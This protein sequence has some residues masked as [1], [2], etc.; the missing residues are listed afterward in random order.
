MTARAES[1]ADRAETRAADRASLCSRGSM[2][3]P[4]K[5]PPSPSSLVPAILRSALPLGIDVESLAWRFDLPPDVL[6]REEVTVAADTAH[7][8]LQAI[9]RSSAD[10]D[11]ALRLS[12]RLTWR[13]IALADLVVRASATVRD[14]LGRLARWAPLVHDGL[15]GALEED[16]AVGRFRVRTPRRPRGL[17]RFVHELALAHAF[18]E[19]R[20]GT[21]DDLVATRVW[22]AHP[23]PPRLTALAAF[24]GTGDLA[25][26]CEDSGFALPGVALPRGL[27]AADPRTVETV[28]PLV[29]QSIAELPPASSLAQRVARRIGT[30]LPGGVDVREVARA[31]HMSARTL[32]R[33]LEDEG[34]RFTE[35]LDRARL[36]AARLLLDD[37]NRS[38]I[39]VALRV[40][41]SDL[42]SFSRAFKRWTG[43]PPGQWRR[44]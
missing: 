24:F 14:A 19:A 15:A 3:R 42:A 40:G 39:D 12:G 31:M 2:G 38:L 21:G 9:A 27:R 29:D 22:F 41:F 13:R 8:L 6:T 4:S 7:E 23:R 16:D 33:R 34:T 28:E 20:S 43:K 17:G 37:P 44:S 36:D 25:F 18:G 11:L 1:F 5:E 32:Q 30:T 35:V 10:D 26:G